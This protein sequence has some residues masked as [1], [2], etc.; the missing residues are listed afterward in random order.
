M[1]TYLIYNIDKIQ[2]ILFM[3]MIIAG[4]LS[5]FSLTE[6]NSTRFAL[7]F[8]AICAVGFITFALLPSVEYL[9]YI[10][11]LDIPRCLAK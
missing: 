7:F 3:L 1:L 4:F 5:I 10:T 8:I 11:Q 6:L 9:C 2:G